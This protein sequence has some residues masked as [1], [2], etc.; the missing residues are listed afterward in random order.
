MSN[1][2]ETILFG[3]QPI[4]TITMNG[5]TKFVA[6]DLC[7]LLGY[8]RADKMLNHF[9]DTAPEYINFKTT[10]GTQSV[11]VVARE[12]LETVLDHC[13]HRNVPAVRT[14]LQNHTRRTTQGFI[15]VGIAI[16]GQ[17]V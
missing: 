8:P 17:E 2:P 15:A 9:V 10:G 16:F 4:R 13:R 5:V 7:H 12:D 3:K 6:R 14:W 11:R 1:Y